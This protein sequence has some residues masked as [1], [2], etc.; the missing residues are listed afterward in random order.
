MEKCIF[1]GMKFKS[2]SKLNEH[3]CDKI[4]DIPAA[5][6]RT[7][8]N[9][10]DL[11]KSSPLL[12]NCTET[13]KT[14]Q[15]NNKPI[16]VEV[17]SLNK[18]YNILKEIEAIKL[19]K[20]NIANEIPYFFQPK[21]LVERM[22]FD[23][24]FDGKDMNFDDV[25]D[26]DSIED[27]MLPCTQEHVLNNGNSRSYME[28]S[29]IVR[30][31]ANLLILNETNNPL[32]VEKNIC[33][34]NDEED[35]ILKPHVGSIRVIKNTT[36][37]FIDTMDYQDMYLKSVRQWDNKGSLL[38][39]NLDGSLNRLENM[40]DVQT[41]KL[42][43]AAV[44]KKPATKVDSV[45]HDGENRDII[46]DIPFTILKKVN[47]ISACDQIRDPNMRYASNN[48]LDK[49]HNLLLGPPR[50]LNHELNDP[51]DLLPM[52]SNRRKKNDGQ[53]LPGE[54]FH[55]QPASM[56]I[57]T[58]SNEMQLQPGYLVRMNNK[59]SPSVEASSKL[60]DS[61]STL[62]HDQDKNITNGEAGLTTSQDS[63]R[64]RYVLSEQLESLPNLDETSG[65]SSLLQDLLNTDHETIVSLQNSSQILTPV[66]AEPISTTHT[67]NEQRISTESSPGTLTNNDCQLVF[68]NVSPKLV[69][70][71][72]ENPNTN[73]TNISS[74]GY[75][76]NM[77]NENASKEGQYDPSA[78]ISNTMRPLKPPPPAVQF[79]AMCDSV[80]TESIAGVHV[81]ALL[82]TGRAALEV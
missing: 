69:P 66:N 44:N 64:I 55:L 20:F 26:V 78:M 29:N 75:V 53:L 57:V 81:S 61:V 62:N 38:S 8:V 30:D 3:K 67:S 82:T 56:L 4:L 65:H 32:L 40:S 25:I 51:P 58:D 11:K 39:E 33:N 14:I 47:A 18:S 79:A 10:D 31:D 76:I 49:G 43:R 60:A 59:N 46:D 35:K 6:E 45:A 70:S 72:Q 73:I 15:N 48:L 13:T 42:K 21:V 24:L 77:A 17:R 36:A 23:S 12:N 34:N 41:Y 16:I 22:D 27:T 71:S 54:V 68:Q 63:C 7:V 52:Q 1:C 50:L 74:G 37:N 2:R 5:D 9:I 80:F 19:N 28:K